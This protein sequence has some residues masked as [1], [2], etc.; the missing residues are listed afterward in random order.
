MIKTAKY[1][2]SIE[3]NNYFH[4]I[5]ILSSYFP[6]SLNLIKYVIKY[7]DENKKN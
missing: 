7:L 3:D 5:N 2:G 6:P 4:L 1:L